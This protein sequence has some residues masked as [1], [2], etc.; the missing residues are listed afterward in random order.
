MRETELVNGLQD[1]TE[2]WLFVSEQLAGQ[3]LQDQRDVV[4]D[5]RVL[6]KNNKKKNFNCVS[7]H[8]KMLGISAIDNK[9][10]QIQ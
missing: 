8:L 4:Q 9:N 5:H 3:L 10:C 1:F 6:K 7:K 2:S